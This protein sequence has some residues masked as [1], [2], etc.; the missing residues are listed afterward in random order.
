MLKARVITALVLVFGLFAVL[1][2]LPLEFAAGIF[3]LIAA[4]AAWEWAGLLRSARL[5]RV[6]YGGLLPLLCFLTAM[7]ELHVWWWGLAAVF[8]CCIVPFWLV[9]RWPLAASPRLGYLVGL[10]LLVPAWSGMVALQ[11]RSPWWLLGIMALVAAADVGAYFA[12]RRFGKHKLAP[13]ISPGKTW[14]GV[15]GGLVAV[16][17][18]V[19]VIGIVTGRPAGGGWL[20]LLLAAFLLTAASIAGDLFESLVKRQAGMKDSSQLLPGHG[21][22]LDRVDSLTATL[23]LAALATLGIGL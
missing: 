8:W 15:G 13:Q 20:V 4:L 23:P 1:F 5:A 9:H 6:A 18:Y 17:L 16:A 22:V 14:E 3:A 11:Q 19:L 2:L 12:G 21:G 7:Y 10:V